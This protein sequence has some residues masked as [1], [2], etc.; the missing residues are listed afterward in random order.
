MQSCTNYLLRLQITRRAVNYQKCHFTNMATHAFRGMLSRI[1][2]AGKR[3]LN[4][5]LRRATTSSQPKI[6]TGPNNEKIIMPLKDA[7]Y[8]E[9]LIH[10]LVWKDSENYPNHIALVI[11]LI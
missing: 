7:S 2:N 10:E 8:P 9:I 1:L 11:F 4:P 5:T 3:T 6:V